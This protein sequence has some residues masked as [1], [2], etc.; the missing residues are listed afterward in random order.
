MDNP[1]LSVENLAV[2]FPPAH[3]QTPQ[4]QAVRGVSFE[5]ERGEI[6]GIVGESGSG[7]SVAVS[8]I[9]GLLPKTARAS[10][11][12]KIDGEELLN[13]DSSFLRGYRGKRIGM[14]FQEPS[15]SYDPLQRMGSVFFESFNAFE[16]LTR[17]QSDERASELLFETGIDDA[18]KRLSGFPHQFSG[19]QL[20]RIGIALALS[21]NC[22]LLIA[23]EPTTALDVTIQAQI[24]SLLKEIRSRRN[25]AIIFIS[26]NIDVVAAIADR[27]LVM[28][29]GLAMESGSA[30]TLLN[31][32]QH[33]YTSALLEAA[34]RFGSHYSQTRLV[35]IPGK[36]PDPR[37]PP[38]GCPFAPRCFFAEKGVCASGKKLLPLCEMECEASPRQKS[39]Q[40]IPHITRCSQKP[41]AESHH[42]G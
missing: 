15:R 4:I 24:V 12:V 2:A 42:F 41:D 10:G 6:L 17:E 7:K 33:P 30:G 32:P 34:P 18:K 29:A 35:S 26:H 13:K 27:I 31:A 16:P 23:D 11:S 20:Q 14:I 5:L 9:P 36:M 1:L 22:D 37:E 39:E 8:A 19:G 25:I 28:Y 38:V 40:E 21:Q 3:P